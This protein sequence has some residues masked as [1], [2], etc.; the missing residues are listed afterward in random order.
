LGKLKPIF[1]RTGVTDN[2]FSELLSGEL[3]EGMKVI[4]GEATAA[5]AAAANQQRGPGG[6]PGMMFMGGG[7]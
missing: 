4:L 7:R 3:K 1:V 6:M 5:Q 2:T